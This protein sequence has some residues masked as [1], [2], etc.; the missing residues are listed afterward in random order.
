[1]QF[2]IINHYHHSGVQAITFLNSPSISSRSSFLWIHAFRPPF[3]FFVPDFHIILY[4]FYSVPVK[5]VVLL[6]FLFLVSSCIFFFN[7]LFLSS[8][9]HQFLSF[10]SVSIPHL[11]PLSP[12]SLGFKQSW[13]FRE[14]TQVGKANVRA[15]GRSLGRERRGILLPVFYFSLFH[16]VIYNS[17]IFHWLTHCQK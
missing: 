11:F 8:V 14:N 5:T 10:F 15:N 7:H 12:P 16:F 1:M 4:Q 17:A 13:W 2:D 6:L 9:L 3:S